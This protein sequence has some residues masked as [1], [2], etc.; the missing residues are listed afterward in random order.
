MTEKFILCSKRAF[1]G[2]VGGVVLENSSGGKP[3]EPIFFLL[4]S[5]VAT[6]LLCFVQYQGLHASISKRLVSW[7]IFAG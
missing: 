5:A 2:S 1:S 4:L 6:G 3:Q 7:Y